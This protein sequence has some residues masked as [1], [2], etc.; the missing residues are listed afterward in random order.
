MPRRPAPGRG[1][2]ASPRGR[3]QLDPA[4]PNGHPLTQPA[5]S[6]YAGRISLT[7]SAV[8]VP[9]PARH[10]HDLPPAVRRAQA[11]A[12]AADPS[13]GGRTRP[14]AAFPAASAPGR[15]RRSG[16]GH[17]LAGRNRRNRATPAKANMPSYPA[18]RSR[19]V[20]ARR[21][22]SGLVPRAARTAPS[23]A[24]RHP[25]TRAAHARW[26]GSAR[27][28][29]FRRALSSARVPSAARTA[30]PRTGDGPRGCGTAR[31]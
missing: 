7:G 9:G 21:S 24:R 22:R 28:P 6:T 10:G 25:A 12:P 1:T 26:S 29:R 4:T 23:P 18:W 3:C 13:A 30:V 17:S 11:Q 31:R 5:A 16:H 14:S 20:A 8:T 2:A 27:G 15:S 19:S